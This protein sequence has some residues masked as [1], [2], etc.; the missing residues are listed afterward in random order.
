MSPPIFPTL[1]GVTYPVKR[2][3]MWRTLHQ[4]SVSG[5]DNPIPLWSFPR[6]RYELTYS[7]FNSGASAFQGLPATEFQALAAFF[8]V[9]NGGASVF[10]YTDVDDGAVTNQLFGTGD[11]ATVAF[12]LSR[13]MT[14]AG[15][16]TFN[17]P[18]FAPTITN[19]KIAGTPTGAYTLGT[20]GLVT[21]TS[22][23][24]NGAALTWTGTFNWLCRFDEDSSQFEKFMNNLWEL[25]SIRFTTIKTQSK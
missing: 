7:A 23:P 11:G 2:F 25:K 16:V 19:V 13:T 15:G 8:N 22:A 21:F 20:Q 14:G 12:A 10:Q 4:E 17:E 3:P 1:K 9:V 24:A 5:Q 6:W 18:V